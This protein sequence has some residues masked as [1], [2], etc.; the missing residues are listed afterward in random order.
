MAS[1][2]ISYLLSVYYTNILSKS[3]TKKNGIYTPYLKFVNFN[4]S[5]FPLIGYTSNDGFSFNY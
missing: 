1:L 2:F 4:I 5:F 3:A